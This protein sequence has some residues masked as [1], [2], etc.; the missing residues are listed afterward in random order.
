MGKKGSTY[1]L[2]FNIMELCQ[3]IRGGKSGPEEH[4]LP[5]LVTRSRQGEGL[6]THARILV[7]AVR[8][9]VTV[10][11]AKQKVL[12]FPAWREHKRVGTR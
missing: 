5:M 8:C 10:R 4:E 2:Y 12:L 11:S 1:K 7:C 3:L 9:A 6:P